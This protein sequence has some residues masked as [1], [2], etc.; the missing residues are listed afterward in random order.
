MPSPSLGIDTNVPDEL[1]HALCTTLPYPHSCTTTNTC[2]KPLMR[3]G[4]QA[5]V[6]PALPPQRVTPVQQRR[7]LLQ[8]VSE[9]LTGRVQA[10]C[11]AKV[12]V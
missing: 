4:L 8:T 12:A 10:D 2:L 9:C 6:A 5:A 11:N 1:F 3:D 7:V